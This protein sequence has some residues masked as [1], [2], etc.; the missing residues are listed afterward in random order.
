MAGAVVPLKKIDIIG[1]ACSTLLRA[2]ISFFSKMF[3]TY[4]SKLQKLIKYIISQPVANSECISVRST[5]HVPLRNPAVSVGNILPVIEMKTTTHQQKHLKRTLTFQRTRPRKRNCEH[6]RFP[7]FLLVAHKIQYLH[8]INI[9]FYSKNRKNQAH[10]PDFIGYENVVLFFFFLF[11]DHG[12]GHRRFGYD[13]LSFS[14]L[15]LL[16]LYGMERS[17]R[18]TTMCEL[19]DLSEVSRN[20]WR[21]CTEEYCYWFF[22]N[23]RLHPQGCRQVFRIMCDMARAN[24]F[25]ICKKKKRTSWKFLTAFRTFLEELNNHKPHPKTNCFFA[26]SLNIN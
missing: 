7:C 2:M 24:K 12:D 13:R 21:S 10:P 11:Q 25:P 17:I 1:Q 26:S 14:H 5:I 6:L 8:H 20:Y 15:S 18:I 3:V 9:H 4:R 16:I 23:Y 22:C 19:P